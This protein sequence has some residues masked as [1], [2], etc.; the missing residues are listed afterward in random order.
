MVSNVY[1]STS[2][3]SFRPVSWGGGVGGELLASQP[4]DVLLYP[5]HN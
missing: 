2:A 3:V 4:W 1:F 5:L